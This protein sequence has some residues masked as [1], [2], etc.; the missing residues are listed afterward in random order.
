VSA[1]GSPGVVDVSSGEGILTS[2]NVT[3][4]QCH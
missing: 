3:D 4:D 2:F 1:P